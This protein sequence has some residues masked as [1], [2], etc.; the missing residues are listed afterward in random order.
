MLMIAACLAMAAPSAWAEEP[1]SD[2]AVQLE[3]VVVTSNRTGQTILETPSNIGVITSDEIEAMDAKTLPEVLKKIPGVYFSDSSSFSPHVNLRGTRVGM[4][5][6]GLVLLNG[7]PMS[8]G[9]YGYV[10]WDAIPV[11][12]IQ[13]VEVVKGP[14]S[15]LYGGDAARGVINIVT[16]RDAALLKG[17]VSATFGEYDDERYSALVY[18]SKDKFDYNFNVKKRETDG[19]RDDA[20]LDNWNYS[21]DAG[22]WLNDTSRLGFFIN[23]SDSEKYLPKKLTKDEKEEDPRQTPDRSFTDVTDVISGLSLK[24][25]G[26]LWDFD[27][28]TYYKNRDKNYE[29]Y[30]KATSTP[31]E[32]KLD[33]DI[34]GV[35]SILTYKQ[36]LFGFNNKLSVGF[37][38]DCDQNEI[39]KLKAASKTE[40]APY[41][42][43]DPKGSGDFKREM[44]GLFV[45]DEFSLMDNLTLTLGVRYDHFEYDNDADYDFSQ[46]GTVD[47]DETPD[48]DKWNPRIGINYR[49]IE[50]LSVYAAYNEAYRPL[51]VYDFYSTG[52][53]AADMPHELK[54]EKFTEYE[55]GFRYYFSEM[56]NVDISI[57]RIEI[58]DM[59]DTYYDKDGD[60]AGKQNVGEACQQG[61]EVSFSGALADNRVRYQVGYTYT[62][63]R[64]VDSYA[65][66][67]D[68]NVVSI[69]DNR[70][71]KIPYNRVTID[72]DTVV[73]RSND[74]ELNWHIGLLTQDEYP[75]DKLNTQKYKDY[76]LVESKMTF[77]YKGAEFFVAVDNLFDED[78]DNYAYV[79]SGKD[80]Y[81]PA[82]GRTWT[83]GVAFAF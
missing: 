16:K 57:F 30:L 6:G 8:M 54:P 11:E 69:D 56:L 40:G 12:N 31:Y 45:Q 78:Y 39:E 15:S 50:K 73:W 55:T 49:P 17:K 20:G 74:Y 22:Y 19:Y 47:Y 2:Q 32:E 4:S 18:G 28:T 25:D 5:E 62:D 36:P 70:L 23:V 13:R 33:G 21:A 38:Y 53:Y 64:Y 44:L 3:E 27:G 61:L 51:T 72:L 83:T 67:Y 81:Y 80:Y 1:A 65:K 52:A 77:H 46:S 82:G 43:A 34:W 24:M 71:S 58:E 66:D 26:S 76:T 68:G 10:D 60:Y 37:D 41:T 9:K 7:I 14:L 42:K 29:N 79:S 48:F 35:R 75:M 59:L 63:A